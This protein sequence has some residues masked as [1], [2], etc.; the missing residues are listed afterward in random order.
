MA[1]SLN[2]HLVVE[3]RPMRQAALL[4]FL[5]TSSFVFWSPLE[6]QPRTGLQLTQ[7]EQY[8]LP[9][10]SGP[11]AEN[12]SVEAR[13]DPV[14]PGEHLAIFRW[15]PGGERDSRQRVDLTSFR[16]GFETAQFETVALLPGSQPSVDWRGGEAGIN[17]YW[18]VLTLTPNG[19]VPS[20]TARYEA[21]TCPVDF[22]QPPNVP[23]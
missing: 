1:V 8:I 23:Q 19:W 11:S 22:E 16:G 15:S 14:Y 12:L 4:A 7:A 9:Q 2:A 5:I 18:R 17:Y 13:C 6:A 20:A 10:G 21:P 3:V